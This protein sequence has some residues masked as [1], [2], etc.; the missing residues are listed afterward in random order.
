[1]LIT[2]QDKQFKIN[3]DDYDFIIV[4]IPKVSKKNPDTDVFEIEKEEKHSIVAIPKNFQDAESLLIATY[5]NEQ[6]CEN[7]FNTL[8]N[9]QEDYFL[10]EEIC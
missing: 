9:I 7:I 1:M 10:P 4:L 3:K 6:F 2:S 5:K 8:I